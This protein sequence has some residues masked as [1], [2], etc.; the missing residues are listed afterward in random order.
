MQVR[1]K[2]VYNRN[3]LVCGYKFFCYFNIH[4]VGLDNV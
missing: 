1:H 2:P 3:H 4:V